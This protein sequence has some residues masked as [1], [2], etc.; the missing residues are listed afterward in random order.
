[1]RRFVTAL[2]L[3]LFC[4]SNA[5]AQTAREPRRLEIPRG[6]GT[7]IDVAIWDRGEGASGATLVLGGSDCLKN[8]Y[9]GWMPRVIEGATTR[10]VISVDKEAAWDNPDACDPAYEAASVEPRRALDVI[11]A[12]TWLKRDLS[13][14]QTGGFH[15]IATSAGG[16]PACAAA[17]ATEDVGALALMSTAGGASFEADMRQLTRNAGRI[18][19]E[20]DRV[21]SD[22][23][24]GQ[25]WLGGTNP[26]IWWWS[27]LPLDCSGQMDGWRGP[28]LILHGSEDQSSPVTSARR[29]AEVL[30][31]RE[32]VEV[33]YRELP[34]AG[35]D[36]FIAAETKPDGGDG[37]DIALGW[38][39]ARATD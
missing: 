31:G 4:I 8:E 18:G 39:S 16:M 32:G 26:E 10:W 13:L 12:M 29:L 15:V 3:S 14:P 20:M 34:G 7:T 22:P 35:H 38:L 11:R 6:D 1:M 28:V 21:R 19:E 17:G 24:L 9:R 5:A 23:R 2:L 33:E 30:G 25:T 27:A 36:L 37:L